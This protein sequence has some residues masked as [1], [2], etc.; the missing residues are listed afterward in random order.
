MYKLPS[1]NPTLSVLILS[2]PTNRG[3]SYENN[4]VEATEIIISYE[5]DFV[6]FH[7]IS[8]ILLRKIYPIL[9]NFSSEL[10][11]F[12]ITDLKFIIVNVKNFSE[13]VIFEQ[14]WVNH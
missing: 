8:N 11:I 2:L 6:E 1:N 3:K 4:I 10:F 7:P 5:E 9:V 12:F 13:V 14:I